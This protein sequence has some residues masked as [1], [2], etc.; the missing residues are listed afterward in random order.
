[1]SYARSKLFDILLVMWTLFIGLSIPLLALVRDPSLVRLVSRF[2]SRGIILGLW[3]IVGLRYKEVGKENVP[4]SQCIYAC[5]HQSAWETLVFNVLIKDVCIVLKKSLYGYP[6]VGWFLKCSPMIAVDRSQGWRSLRKLV[7]EALRVAAD[8]RSILIFP[9]GTRQPVYADAPF[10]RGILALYRATELPVVP[11]AINSGVYWSPDGFMKY[12]GEVEVSYM[13]PIAP[14]LP[15]EEFLQ[16]LED[17]IKT[18]KNR[19]VE[20][21]DIDPWIDAYG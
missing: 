13:A 8:G 10:N 3:Y 1:M 15:D 7:A 19:L 11:V 20:E 14:G 21:L 16:R 5:N 2:W 17:H 4:Q 18:E 12:S 9:E 6:I